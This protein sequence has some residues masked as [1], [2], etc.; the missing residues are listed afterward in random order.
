[1]FLPS[2]LTRARIK[3][4]LGRDNVVDII[5]L[6]SHYLRQ[7]ATIEYFVF[8]QFLKLYNSSLRGHET[9]KRW[10]MLVTLKNIKCRPRAKNDLS[11]VDA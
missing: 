6:P 5:H 8:N 7:L 11:R 9:L 2:S 3:S 4:S 10:Q 1:M